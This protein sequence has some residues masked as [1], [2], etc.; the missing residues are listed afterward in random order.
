MPDSNR[1]GP[2]LDAL[3]PNLPIHMGMAGKT[4][5]ITGGGSGIG[6]ATALRLA[7][8]GASVAIAARDR[9]R[10]ELVA[11][12]L[13]GAGSTPLAITCDVTSLDDARAAV[14]ETVRRLG[15]LD[16][17]F[18]NAG[19]IYRDR[20]VIETTVEEWDE[21]FAVNVRGTF[22][23]S[24]AAI[25]HMQRQG[26]G[27][28]VNNASY[29]G[30]VGGVGT[31]AYS[32]SKGAVVLLTKAMALDHAADGIRVNA[33]CPGSV[34][35]PMLAMEMEELGGQDQVRPEFEAK[36][37]LGRIATPAEVA[38]TVA[39]LASDEAAFIT[40]IALPVDGGITAG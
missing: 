9:D 13:R 19:V 20:S 30:L 31:A 2:V 15:R 17:L 24:K 8:D 39:F 35:T 36:H 23:M 28:I 10:L 12:E 40:G 37:P 6:R 11:D 16:I 3:L 38:A 33:V 7:S 14:D 32:A 22:F 4:A 5:L 18:N 25:P 1:P 34:D 26:G 21:T 29:F 27:V